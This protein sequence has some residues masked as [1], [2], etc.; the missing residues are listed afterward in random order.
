V[1]TAERIREAALHEFEESGVLRFRV[2]SVAARAGCATSVLY[3]HFASREG[4]LYSAMVEFV[5]RLVRSSGARTEVELDDAR[6]AGDVGAYL[7]RAEARSSTVA[8][9]WEADTLAVVRGLSSASLAL[10]AAVSSLDAT[11]ARA[12]RD[13]VAELRSR[14]LLGERTDDV[15]V[16]LTLEAVT[17]RWSAGRPVDLFDVEQSLTR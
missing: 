4:L 8:A 7:R 9:R 13:V 2:S 12:R 6:S 5:D 10:Q 16:A 14:G 3:H 1:S 11:T 17:E 15:A